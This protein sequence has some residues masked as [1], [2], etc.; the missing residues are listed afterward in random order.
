MTHPF[1][2]IGNE[3]VAAKTRVTNIV[4]GVTLIDDYHWL[5]ADNWQ[6]ALESSS[7]VKWLIFDMSTR[8]DK[9][10]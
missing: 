6:E 8:L 5:R 1:K 7:K 4:R 10:G 2:K 3:P 9:C